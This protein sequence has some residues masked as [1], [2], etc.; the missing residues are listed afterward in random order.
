MIADDHGG[1]VKL[2]DMEEAEIEKL[3]E[4][5]RKALEEHLKMPGC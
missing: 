1:R 5:C 3:K 2:E 4:R